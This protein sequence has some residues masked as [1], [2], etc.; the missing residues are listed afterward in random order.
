MTALID[1][2]C[3]KTVRALLNEFSQGRLD[4]FLPG[5]HVETY[6]E[7]DYNGPH[8]AAIEVNDPA[9][10]R[11]IVLGGDVGLGEA[12][13]A[14]EWDTPD[15]A[16]VIAWLLL[17]HEHLA[18]GRQSAMHK[19]AF[20]LLG[21]LNRWR[22][23]QRL[24]SKVGSRRNIV[25]HYDLGNDFYRLFL[26]RTMTYSSAR[27]S[28]PQQDLA[29]AQEDK[30]RILCER[31]GLRQGHRVLEI[32]CGWGGFA[33]YA[34][35]HYGCQVTAVTL[36][37]SQHQQALEGIRQDGLEGHVEA[38]IRDYR[39]LEGQFDRIVS[40]EMLEAVGA[41]YLKRF[42]AGCHRMLKPEGVL[43]LQVILCPESKYEAYRKGVDWVQK[44]IFPGGHLPS[45]QAILQAVHS[46]G[47][48]YLH[49]LETFGQHYAET[50]RRWRQTFY[51]HLDEVRRQGF[52][53]TFIRRWEYY[54]AYCE[55][56]FDMRN[57]TVGHLIFTRPNNLDFMPFGRPGA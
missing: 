16:R 37:P 56:G 41:E 11:R 13:E 18:D 7:P 24:N 30:Y 50:L 33:R 22:H 54:L 25:A 49:Q 44:Y 32:G 31:V 14:G 48:L 42:F 10:F 4:L 40:I 57:I 53:D 20:N 38:F 9:F 19:A 17:N 36:S 28:H 46:T 1:R 52:P 29:D 39:E 45:L 5:G 27:F 21:R 55:A 23:R 6:G 43:G 3:E 35:R 51:G 8:L 34:A 26:D 15:P 12:Y 2:F 47:D